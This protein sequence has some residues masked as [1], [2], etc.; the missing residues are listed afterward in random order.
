MSSCELSTG[1]EFGSSYSSRF[2]G[3][4]LEAV[5]PNLSEPY[6]TSCQISHVKILLFFRLV[7]P[8]LPALL[9]RVQ[10]KTE[11]TGVE[12]PESA[13]FQNLWKT[14]TT[15]NEWGRW[16]KYRRRLDWFQP[17]SCTSKSAV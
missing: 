12:S 16:Y 2:G 3:V 5:G 8:G 11:L 1:I 7:P 13:G 4:A 9:C 15:N 14:G 6:G 17:D 10:K